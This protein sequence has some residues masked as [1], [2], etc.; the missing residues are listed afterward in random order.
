MK[1]KRYIIFLG[2][3]SA[4]VLL[5]TGPA[6]AA[7]HFDLPS[8]VNVGGKYLRNKLKTVLLD[9]CLIWCLGS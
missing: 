5:I 3:M 9:D 2:L 4:A 6:N 1:L 7:V 8:A